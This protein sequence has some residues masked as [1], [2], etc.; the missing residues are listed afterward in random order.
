M[1]ITFIT[2]KLD[3]VVGGGANRGLDIKLRNLHAL[4]HDVRLITIFPELNKLPSEGVPYPIEAAP[5]AD[6]TFTALQQHVVA[7]LKQNE[8]RS[9]VYHID[10]TT[11]MWA[12]GMYHKAGGPI[13]TV[14][15]L[16]T[17]AEALNLLTYEPPDIS[18]GLFPWLKFN[19]DVRMVWL[20]HWLWAKW[21][22]L[23]YV[24]HLDRIF[25]DS[26]VLC[27][28]YARFGFPKHL[29]ETMPEFV[30]ASH[31]LHKDV[32]GATMPDAFGTDRPFR[33]LHVGRLLR[34]K[35]VDLLIKAVVR[36]RREGR[37]VTATVLGDGPQLERLQKLAENL[38][39][40]EAITFLP[41]TDETKLAPVYAACDAFV[42]PCRFPEPFGRTILEALFFDRP[43]VTS[44]GTGS[45]W[46]AGNA[47][48]SAR[49]GSMDDL[50]RVLADLY[51]NPKRLAELSAAAPER[52]EYFDVHRWTRV[53]ETELQRLC[54][55]HL[56]R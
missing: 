20:K 32:R 27:A 23:G 56:N 8:S 24:R 40:K 30:D 39:V 55:T 26:P 41:W 31:F 11:C 47:G 28:N 22:G 14:V 53:L 13:P 36:L 21:V 10:G 4:G 7:I 33:L 43:I 2:L 12:G 25:G 45:A 50:V 16:P 1:R 52:V 17:Y 37:N 44:V 19:I 48:V 34:M 6:R 5:C 42:H 46:V 54:D 38:G 35:G 51:D 3:I 9:D 15:Y 29:L 18:K 49:M